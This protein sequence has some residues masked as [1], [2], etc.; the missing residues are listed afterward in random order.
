[1]NNRTVYVTKKKI[2]IES[3][4]IVAGRS[5]G[6]FLTVRPPLIRQASGVKLVKEN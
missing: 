1:M 2:Y 3:L 5:G 4:H 6:H